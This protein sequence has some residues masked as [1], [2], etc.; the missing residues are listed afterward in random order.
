MHS[1][2]SAYAEA[3]EMLTNITR[4]IVKNGFYLIDVTGNHTTWGVWAPAQLNLECACVLPRPHLPAGAVGVT[5]TASIRFK[6]SHTCW[7]PSNSREYTATSL[8]R[9]SPLVQ[10]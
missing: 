10:W 3:V 2:D 6:S 7:R 8:W 9:G 5:P 1:V 4:Y